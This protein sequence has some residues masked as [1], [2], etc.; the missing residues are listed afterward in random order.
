MEN[1]CYEF[2]SC[3]EENETELGKEV[4][5]TNLIIDAKKRHAESSRFYFESFPEQCGN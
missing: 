1:G 4:W 2:P 3:Q 5:S